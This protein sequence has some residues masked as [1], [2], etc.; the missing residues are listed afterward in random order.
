MC[1]YWKS[2][3]TKNAGKTQ[4]THVETPYAELILENWTMLD[5]DFAGFILP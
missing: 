5:Q 2:K 3:I 4:P 1:R